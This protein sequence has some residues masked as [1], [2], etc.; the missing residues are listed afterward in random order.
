MIA[1]Y[2]Q[3]KPC[4]DIDIEIITEDNITYIRL[5]TG[6][7]CDVIKVP[8]PLGVDPIAFARSMRWCGSDKDCFFN[9]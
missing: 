4:D 7:Y 2:K 9:P 6:Y 1:L 5:E 3:T 8:V